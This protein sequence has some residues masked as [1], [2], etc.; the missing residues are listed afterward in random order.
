MIM[1]IHES[2]RKKMIFRL[3]AARIYEEFELKNRYTPISKFLK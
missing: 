1:N 2:N 3:Q